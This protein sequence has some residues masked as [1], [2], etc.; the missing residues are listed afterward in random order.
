MISIFVRPKDTIASSTQKEWERNHLR[1]VIGESQ[2]QYQWD[3]S[4]SGI[5]L[6]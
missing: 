1:G 4:Q 2:Q 6:P 5:G 3:W